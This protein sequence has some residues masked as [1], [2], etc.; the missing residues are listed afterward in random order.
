MPAHK[1]T[2]IDIS[3]EAIELAGRSAKNNEVLVDFKEKDFFSD[4]FCEYLSRFDVIVSNPP[5]ISF[6]DD[7]VGEFTR[8]HEPHKALFASDKGM[9]FYKRFAKMLSKDQVLYLELNEYLATDIEAL[10]EEG[11][12]SCQIRKDLQGKDRMMRVQF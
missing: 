2:A 10:F 9:A 1:L 5:Y 12:T 3:V 7:R 11:N 8:L 6:E 4:D